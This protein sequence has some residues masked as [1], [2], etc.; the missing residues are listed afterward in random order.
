MIWTVHTGFVTG[1]AIGVILRSCP[2]AGGVRHTV[3]SFHACFGLVE[4]WKG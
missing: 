3:V 2:L 4:L 1:F